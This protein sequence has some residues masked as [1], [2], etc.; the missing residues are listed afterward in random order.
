MAFE[1]ATWKLRSAPEADVERS[2]EGAAMSIR[3]QEWLATPE[4]SIAN[5][6]SWGHNLSRFKHDP[7]SEN[8]AL[9]VQIEM[10]LARKMPQDIDD[11]R[12][13][14]VGVDVLDIDLCK[15]TIVHQYG[16]ENIQV[17]L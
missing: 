17:Q 1:E 5:H 14:A 11:L 4:G 6:P 7:L 9:A 13:V 2:Y 16:T 10:A 15:I 12:L 8:G 3:I